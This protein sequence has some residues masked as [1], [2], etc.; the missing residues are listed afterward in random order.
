MTRQLGFPTSLF[1]VFTT[2]KPAISS[3][4]LVTLG[5]E[6]HSFYS[7][8]LI[9]T[10]Y[11]NSAIMAMHA[12][13]PAAEKGACLPTYQVINSSLSSALRMLCR[14]YCGCTRHRPPATIPI[15]SGPVIP[16]GEM[17][18]CR[19]G[20]RRNGTGQFALNSPCSR[21]HVL[22]EILNTYYSNS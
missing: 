15:C 8:V 12:S 9:V 20:V 4:M 13:H 1:V 18:H 7:E 11:R 5:G 10:Q 19:L 21:E 2:Q 17:R 22:Y 3:K 14:L 6:L 16:V